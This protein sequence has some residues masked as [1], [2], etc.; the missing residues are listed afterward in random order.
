MRSRSV[1]L[2]TVGL[3]DWLE[4]DTMLGEQQ[5]ARALAFLWIADHDDPHNMG[6]VQHDRQ[7][8]RGQLRTSRARHILVGGF[9]PIASSSCELFR[10]RTAAVA[11]AALSTPKLVNDLL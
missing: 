4:I 1:P 9:A 10:W 11:A 5:V 7:T 3:I 2:G 6:L 8:R